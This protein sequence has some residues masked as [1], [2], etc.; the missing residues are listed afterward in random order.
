M[1]AAMRDA[2]VNAIFIPAT[3]FTTRVHGRI[4]EFANRHRL[5]S[6]SDS[7][8][9]VESGVLVG[10]GVDVPET[11][12]RAVDY[13]DRILRGARPAEMAVE[14]PTKFDLSVNLKTAR[15]IGVTVP[16]S[17]LLRARR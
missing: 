7:P 9:F 13:V 4:V 14:M 16:R 1:L 12:R 2:R 3:T 15:A 11:M 10:Y 6:A 17:I 5:P 8:Q